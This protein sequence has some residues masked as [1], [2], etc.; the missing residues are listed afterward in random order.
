MTNIIMLGPPGSGKGT[1]AEMISEKYGWP[2]ISTGNILRHAIEAKS[3]LGLEA[4]SYMGRG[5]L[6]PDEVVD[7]IVAERLSHED[8]RSGFILDG[9]PRDL[10][11]AHALEEIASIDHVFDIRV[12]DQAIVDRLSKRRVC[13]CG[14]TYHLEYNPPRAE[15]VCDECGKPLYQRDDDNEGTIRN[16]LKVYHEKTEPLIGYYR[17]KGLLVELDGTRDI[18]EVFDGMCSRLDG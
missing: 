4:E 16:R 3:K 11:Q 15:G 2:Q 9:F 5:E 13:D 14:E 6:V 18:G 1:Q 17:E 12:P 8:C 7:G 10:H